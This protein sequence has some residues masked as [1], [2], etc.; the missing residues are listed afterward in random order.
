MKLLRY[1]LVGGSA[2]LFEWA[3]FWLLN[4]EIKLYYLIAAC[5]SYIAATIINY[6]LSIIHVFKSE[7]RF[8][9]HYELTLIFIIGIIGLAVSQFFM[10]IFIG[11]LGFLPMISKIAT[12]GIVFGWNYLSRAHFVFKQAIISKK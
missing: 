7:S 3:L 2:A 10:L 1:L 8:S 4:Y 11:Y 5:I 12:T 9:R 6:I